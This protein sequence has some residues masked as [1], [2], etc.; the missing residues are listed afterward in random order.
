[1]RILLIEDDKETALT[2]KAQLAS[3]F[4]VEIAFN[5]ERG[6]YHALIN[7]YDLIIIDYLLPD[8]QGTVL[9]ERL[10]KAG[11][12]MPILFLTGQSEVEHK[13]LALDA[14]AD[15]YLTKPFRLEELLARIR[16]LLRRQPIGLNSNVLAVDDLTFDLY[17]STVIREGKT[18]PLRKK[19]LYL[20]EYLM[21]NTGRIMTREM[22]LDHVWDSSSDSLTNV[23]DVHIKYLRDKIDKPFE[24]KLI[25]T[26]HGL[27]YKIEA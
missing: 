10:R 9:C 21:R 25:K 18:I 16:A 15:D 4:I 17:K 24:K 20:L 5:G 19:E 14:G 26:I 13:V 23:V 1:M 12:K 2:I 6:E 8:I 27:G 22:I 11:L 7:E 3:H